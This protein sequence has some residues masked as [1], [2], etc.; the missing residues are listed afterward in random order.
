VS[1]KTYKIKFKHNNET[2][3][4][5]QEVGSKIL[6]NEEVVTFNGLYKYISETDAM[7]KRCHYTPDLT[8]I[9]IEEVSTEE[10]IKQCSN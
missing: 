8:E 4:V 1:E 3:F 6:K 9:E 5:G 2:V 10:M 7:Y